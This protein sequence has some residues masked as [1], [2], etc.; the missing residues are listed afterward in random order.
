VIGGD[1]RYFNRCRHP[2]GDPHGCRQR[3]RQGAG[4]AGRHSVDARRLQRHPQIQGLRRHHP[5]GQPQSRR[6]ARAISASSTISAMAARRRR[7]S[8]T[9][10]SRAPRSSTATRS[11]MRADVDLDASARR[12]GGMTVEV[13]DPVADYAE[14][15]ESCSTSRRSGQCSGGFRMRFDA[16]HA[17]TG[18]YATEILEDRLGAPARAPCATARRCPISAAIIPTRTS[19]R[20]GPLRRR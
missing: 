7:R 20:Q 2:E 6:P 9:R 4:G 5:V 19:S 12:L 11:P 16:M 15:M 14:L 17:V 13:I 8:P 1:G 18:P 10:S 3:L